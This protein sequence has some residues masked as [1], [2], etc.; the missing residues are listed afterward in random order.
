[1]YKDEK[2]KTPDSTCLQFKS[3]DSFKLIVDS[4]RDQ[5]IHPNLLVVEAYP[6][7]LT[8]LSLRVFFYVLHVQFAVVLWLNQKK[9]GLNIEIPKKKISTPCLYIFCL[10][11]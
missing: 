1:M 7:P 3:K 6:Q 2:D 10:T 9:F 4:K 5:E 11:S 8:K